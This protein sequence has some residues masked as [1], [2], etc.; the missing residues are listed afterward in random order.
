MPNL[1]DEAH[2]E[3]AFGVA[4][5]HSTREQITW[6]CSRISEF[7]RGVPLFIFLNVS[8]TH[9]PTRGYV[10]GARHE[11]T[12]TQAA[13]LAYVDRQL[14]PLFDALRNRRI[15]GRAFLMSDHGT[16]FGDDGYEG[17]RVGHT[18]VWTVPYGEYHWG[19]TS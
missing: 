3:P 1:F 17:H 18:A 14:P 4:E 8:A 11:S 9:P 10:K 6:A 15:G 5:R 16:L 7:E 19:V 13:A 2:W 12:A